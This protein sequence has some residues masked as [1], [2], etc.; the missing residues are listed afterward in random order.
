MDG[1]KG[2]NVSDA[3]LADCARAAIDSARLSRRVRDVYKRQV[4]LA[5]LDFCR[6]GAS[7]DLPAIYPPK[8]A[9]RIQP[10]ATMI[11]IRPTPL[12]CLARLLLLERTGVL[13]PSP[14]YG[15]VYM[16]P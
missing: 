7:L 9:A 2:P 8:N 6:L 16:A 14:V 10:A 1:A 11:I 3:H 5:V 13:V 12:A 15:A 4:L